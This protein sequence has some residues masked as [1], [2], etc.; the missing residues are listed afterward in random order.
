MTHT[1]KRR[2]CKSHTYYTVCSYQGFELVPYCPVNARAHADFEHD[3]RPH[4]HRTMKFRSFPLE[5]NVQKLSLILD[6]S[7]SSNSHCQNTHKLFFCPIFLLL[8]R[9]RDLPL[10]I[11]S[12]LLFFLRAATFLGHA[13]SRSL[14][15]QRDFARIQVFAPNF[16]LL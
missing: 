2:K 4:N 15:W 16:G 1:N 10:S 5:E 8:C 14:P 9:C 3:P 7:S 6:L 12:R 13:T 11:V